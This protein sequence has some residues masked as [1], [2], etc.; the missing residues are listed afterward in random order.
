MA[1]P[2]R[3]SVRLTGIPLKHQGT[4]DS[5]C[6]YYAAAMLLCALRPELEE[7]FDAA[8][9]DEDPIFGHLPRK[10]GQK[11]ERAVAEWLTS[12]VRLDRLC[13]A[14]N[15]ACARSGMPGVSTRFAWRA[16]N[17][18]RG[19]V[20]FLRDQI[21]RGLPCVLGWESREMG[22]HT[23]LVVGH[24]R[25]SGSHSEWL[26]LHDP[27]RVQE[28]LEWGQLATLADRRVDLLYCVAHDG[29]RPDKL[30]TC[31]GASGAILDGRTRLERWDPRAG[32]YHLLVG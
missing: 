6:A 14:L 26:R 28:L 22:D 10:G 31:R 9:V 25:Y 27:S 15:R 23:V 1:S 2:R 11:I 8:R 21:D 16:G 17:R 12:G 5:L 30:T 7:R 13:D 18:V 32:R 19:N 3:T 4:H 24:E 29:A 20:D